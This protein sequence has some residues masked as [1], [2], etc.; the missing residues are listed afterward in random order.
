MDMRFDNLVMV[1]VSLVLVFF[2][3]TGLRIARWEGLALLASYDVYA[4]VLWP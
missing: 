2:A 3:W 1:G 4:Y